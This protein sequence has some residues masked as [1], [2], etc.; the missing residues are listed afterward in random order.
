MIEHQEA[1]IRKLTFQK[2][3]NEF[4]KITPPFSYE[5]DNEGDEEILKKD[6]LKTFYGKCRN[7]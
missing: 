4:Q 7:L 5:Y 1:A 2:I 6:I 3:G